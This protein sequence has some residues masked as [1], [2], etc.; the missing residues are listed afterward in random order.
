MNALNDMN[1]K[2]VEWDCGTTGIG[3]M[4]SDSLMF[5]RGDPHPG[6]PHLSEVYGLALPLLKR[7]MP[8][9]PV[10]LENVTVPRYLEDF[11]VL[12][13]SYHGMKPLSA[14]VHTALVNWV[15]RGGQ[16]AVFDDDSDP[17]HAVRDWWNTGGKHYATPRQ[18]LFEQLGFKSVGDEANP[19]TPLIW[20]HGKGDV[21]WLKENPLRIA[22]D[23][24]G[25]ERAIQLVKKVVQ[26]AKL[27]WR[28]TNYLLLRRGP[29][30][31]AAGLDESVAGEPKQLRGR[32]VN[33]F[34][35]ELKLQSSI[36]LKPGTRYLLRDLKIERSRKPQL[37]ASGCKAHLLKQEGATVSYAVEGV[38]STSA[39]VLISSAKAP[40]S[41]NLAG[42]PVQEFSHAAA[43]GLLWIRF[44][45]EARPRE[46]TIQF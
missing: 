13:L 1:Q 17:Y 8:I 43:E 3:V 38:G 42:Q 10:Q 4:V 21:F 9:A 25:D 20:R 26:S 29:Y 7:G 30:L 44:A 11:R 23:P 31:V 12:L 15:K 22:H 34:D 32:F 46:L 39:I 24:K 40:R 6:D 36:E 5:Q 45:N 18:H 28:E 19:A 35:P 33:L 2:R 14:D 16:L 41:I 27:R 37:V